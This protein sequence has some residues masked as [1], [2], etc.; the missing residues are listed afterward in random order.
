[1]PPFCKKH[2]PFRFVDFFNMPFRVGP[3]D[4]TNVARSPAAE[5]DRQE[6]EADNRLGVIDSKNNQSNPVPR[7]PKTNMKIQGITTAPVV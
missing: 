7:N 1:M 5:S 4:N 3:D 2:S 6:T